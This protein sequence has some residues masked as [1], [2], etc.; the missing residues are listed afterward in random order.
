[1]IH[2]LF[3]K[4]TNMNLKPLSS[5]CF[6]EIVM[7]FIPNWFTLNIGTGIAFLTLQKPDC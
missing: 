5:K 4:E 7:N 6:S 3:Q 2:I 1:M